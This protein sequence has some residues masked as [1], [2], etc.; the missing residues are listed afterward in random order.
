MTTT[1]AAFTTMCRRDLRDPSSATFTDAE[2]QDL[3]GQGIDS[4]ADFYPKEAITSLSIVASTYTY[5]MPSTLNWPFRVDVYNVDGTFDQVLARAEGNGP[6]GG[7]QT[8]TGIMFI[9][10]WQNYWATGQTLQVFGYGP[11]AYIDSSSASSA[12]TD[13]DQSALAAVRVF[14]QVEAFNRLTMNRAE[15]QQWQQTPGNTDVTA[16]Q[17]MSMARAATARWKTEATRLFR[18]RKQG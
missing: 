8:H 14:V 6:N 18:L 9:P 3:I 5:S 4:V 10:Q 2:I 11:W 7:W 16:L 13:L 12:T 15:F 1:L 17:M